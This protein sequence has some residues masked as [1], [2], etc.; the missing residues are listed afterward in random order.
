ML[1]QSG[2]TD[3]E[4]KSMAFVVEAFDRLLN[5]RDYGAAQG[6]G[7]RPT[8]KARSCRFVLRIANVPGFGRTH[9]ATGPGPSPP[10]GERSA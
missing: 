10:A 6:S 5:K 9:D 7:R 8:F 4:A 3:R 2:D 1:K